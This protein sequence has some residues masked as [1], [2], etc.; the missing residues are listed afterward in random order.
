MDVAVRALTADDWRALRD[1]RLQA[2][3]TEP[4]VFFRRYDEE[5][6][7]PAERWVALAAGDQAHQVFGAFDG[8]RAIAISAVFVD[9]DDPGGTTVRFGMSYVAPAY[10]RRG[11]IARL[12]EARLAWVRARPRVERILV[13][14]RA[15][16]VGSRRAI[17]RFGFCLVDERMHR[18]PD[19][20][21]E[22]DV[23]YE[24]L[25]GP[26]NAPPGNP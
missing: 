21:E 5:A 15:S 18:W 20:T 10:R 14:H 7:R 19:G 12:Y 11:V 6:D 8:S 2:L 22:P 25:L 3:R 24:L 23:N 16:N 9:A 13:S 26:A 17:E 4:G 1:L